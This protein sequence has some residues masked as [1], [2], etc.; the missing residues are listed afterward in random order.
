MQLQKKGGKIVFFHSKEE[1]CYLPRWSCKQPALDGGPWLLLCQ[2]G[3]RNTNAES[4]GTTAL[5][6]ATAPA[7]V[8]AF[9]PQAWGF[10]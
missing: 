4:I 2:P 1:V 7:T 6:A 8:P 9:Q 3:P 5:E 10:A